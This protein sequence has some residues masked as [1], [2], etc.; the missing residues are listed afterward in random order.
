[1]PDIAELQT[2]DATEAAHRSRN[3]QRLQAVLRDRFGL[4][5]RAETHELPVYALIKARNSVRLSR[6]DGQASTFRIDPPGSVTAFAEPIT[7]LATYLSGELGRPV[8]DQTGLD[9]QYDF[10]LDWS[11]DLDTSATR[12]SIFTALTDQLGL[13]LELKKG[14]VQVYAIEKI[15]RP[16]EN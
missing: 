5:L 8:S 7:R 11:P 15:E 1:V 14:P 2:F 12:P 9:G 4:V 16:S 13:R 10:K 6:V 3:W